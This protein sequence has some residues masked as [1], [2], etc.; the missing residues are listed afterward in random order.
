MGTDINIISLESMKILYEIVATNLKLA[1]ERGDPQKQPS[2]TKLQ[3]GDTV[4]NTKSYQR[5]F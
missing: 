1:Q 4:C 2:P 3:P 5:S